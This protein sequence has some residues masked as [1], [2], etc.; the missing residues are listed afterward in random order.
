[1]KSRKLR[2]LALALSAIMTIT[3]VPSTLFAEDFF[4]G[5]AEEDGWDSEI[6]ADVEAPVAEDDFDFGFGSEVVEEEFVEDLEVADFDFLTADEIVAGVMD[7]LEET[8]DEA[9]L[10]VTVKFSDTLTE[11][12]D[13]TRLEYPDDCTKY[14]YTSTV[15]HQG[16][17]YVIYSTSNQN[18]SGALITLIAKKKDGSDAADDIPG[19][20]LDPTKEHKWDDGTPYDM[21]YSCTKNTYRLEYKCQNCG[22]LGYMA[23]GSDKITAA[24]TDAQSAKTAK[25]GAKQV[26]T[27]GTG[28][29][30]PTDASLITVKNI[31]DAVPDGAKNADGTPMKVEN[32]KAGTEKD[33]SAEDSKKDV[34]WVVE[35]SWKCTKCGADVKEYEQKSIQVRRIAYGKFENTQI[36]DSSS[37]AVPTDVTAADFGLASGAVIYEGTD[38]ETDKSKFEVVDCAKSGKFVE[39]WFTTDTVYTTPGVDADTKIKITHTIE[40][41][42]AP[43]TPSKKVY[44]SAPVKVGEKSTGDT[45]DALKK[46]YKLTSKNVP[47][48]SLSCLDA[49]YYEITICQCTNDL[50]TV[51]ACVEKVAPANND[52]H[53]YNTDINQLVKDGVLDVAKK[54]FVKSTTYQN[55][56]D[57]EG[58][59]ANKTTVNFKNPTYTCTK[60]GTVDVSYTC[61]IC[62]KEI[63]LGTF[64]VDAPGHVWTWVDID[65]RQD[66]TCTVDGFVTQQSQCKV[67]QAINPNLEVRKAVI[68]KLNHKGID[69]V[70]VLYLSVAQG[71]D[72]VNGP[73]NKGET[74]Y[75]LALGKELVDV[76]T[77]ETKSTYYNTKVVDAKVY[78]I[79][80]LCGLPVYDSNL[81]TTD[82]EPFVKAEDIDLT[83]TAL[84][85]DTKSCNNGTITVTASCE[86]PLS[87]TTPKEKLTAVGSY[88]FWRDNNSYQART[89]HAAKENADGSIVCMIC[90]KVLKEA[91]VVTTEP[92][93]ETTTEAKP[94]TTTVAPQAETTTVAPQPETTTVAPQPETTTVAPQPETT[95]VAPQPETTTAEPVSE[96]TTEAPATMPAQVT[97]EKITKNSP[98]KGIIGVKY[99]AV[100]GA[101]S[102]TVNVREPNGT[103]TKNPTDGAET[104]YEIT[105]L[106]EGKLYD[107]RIAAVGA[108]IA[109]P[110]SAH[111]YRWLKKVTLDKPKKVK[112]EAGAVTVTWTAADGASK[113]KL[114]WSTDK[115]F[116]TDVKKDVFTENTAKIT[117]LKTGTRYYFKVRCYTKGADDK[118]YTGGWSNVRSKILK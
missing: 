76:K 52:A 81:A 36:R 11:I 86:N 22:K 44:A 10:K 8:W 6:V 19:L 55:I 114:Y 103:W 77:T 41:T 57:L 117:G 100:E 39:Y 88:D 56:S 93:T 15:T 68:P 109:G 5:A 27:E 80:P 28:H 64:N 87:T 43:H 48:A 104:A 33:P 82:V 30:K 13:M 46:L 95:T 108:G 38:Y 25:E 75:A 98:T 101:D 91:P 92:T 7:I 51:L 61:A 113:Y 102:Y 42:V 49:K 67:C 63:A 20:Y 35:T 59:F 107:I 45:P 32:V 97:G 24:P 66:A 17:S 96:T 4:V 40:H 94:E 23:N 78:K 16:E 2:A 9:T 37:L 3:A 74:N 1:M 71:G 90:G 12:G 115:A 21:E 31:I 58:A 34:Y 84:T 85:P 106:T 116:K 60:A 47:E 112:G 72:I 73:K 14:Y 65:P 83:I 110:R 105:G 29:V 62:K 111:L 99:N 54:A 89:Q 18:K 53:Q 118:T 50:N 26:E 79:C 69:K 70:K